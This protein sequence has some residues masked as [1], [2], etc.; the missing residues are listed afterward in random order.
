VRYTE[1]VVSHIEGFEKANAV[2]IGDSLSAEI[3]GANEYGIESIWY[4]PKGKTGDKTMIPT[5]ES[6]SFQG[7]L[8]IL[9]RINVKK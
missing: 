6:A 8:E 9:K 7:I 1:Y 5:Y 3:K 4:N 2:R